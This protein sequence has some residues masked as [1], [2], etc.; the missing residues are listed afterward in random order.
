MVAVGVRV[1]VRR[2][3][4]VPL[5]RGVHRRR[6]RALRRR[7]RP[8]DRPRRVPGHRT[9][10]QRD[11][12]ERHAVHRC[13]QSVVGPRAVRDGRAG[14]APGWRSGPAPVQRHRRRRRRRHFCRVRAGRSTR[15]RVE[16]R[17]RQYAGGHLLRRGLVGAHDFGGVRRRLHHR[18]PRPPSQHHAP[19]ARERN[20]EDHKRFQYRHSQFHV[21]VGRCPPVGSENVF[22]YVLNFTDIS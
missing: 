1:P 15:V 18:D 12:G 20:A 3:L 19:A 14:R 6:L 7:H 21:P 17:R 11:R 8:T 4:P 22:G 13:R 5:S 16:R 2:P 9:R 10:R